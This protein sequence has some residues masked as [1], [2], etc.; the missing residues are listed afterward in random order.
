MQELVQTHAQKRCD[1]RPAANIENKLG[2]DSE[3]RIGGWHDRRYSV[4]DLL[5]V[6]P[7]P[8]Y[9]FLQR[10]L[11]GRPN[12][13][14]EDYAFLSICASYEATAGRCRSL[15]RNA[16]R[17]YRQ[18]LEGEHR[19]ETYGRLR[20]L[21]WCYYP[22]LLAEYAWSHKTKLIRPHHRAPLRRIG[23]R[24]PHRQRSASTR[25]EDDCG[26]KQPR[27]RQRGP[28]AVW[29]SLNMVLDAQSRH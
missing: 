18:R 3:H 12:R 10:S 28:S 25:C 9:E 15:V 23:R 27:F 7:Y 1:R 5:Q 17:K 14:R 20:T 13:D 4:E 2:L 16:Q 21:Y 22:F 6:A 29:P 26:N 19:C 11:I 24:S 8:R